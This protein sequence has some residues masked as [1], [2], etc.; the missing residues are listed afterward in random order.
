MTIKRMFPTDCACPRVEVLGYSGLIAVT[1]AL[2]DG[3]R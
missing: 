2:L 1:D 3:I